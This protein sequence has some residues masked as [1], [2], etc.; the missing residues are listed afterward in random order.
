MASA[1]RMKPQPPR[2]QILNNKDENRIIPAVS[3]QQEGYFNPVDVKKAKGKNMKNSH[4]RNK[5]LGILR[6]AA[7]RR[8]NLFSNI[9][10]QSLYD[11]YKY[12]KQSGRFHL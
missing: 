12:L 1:Q 2:D 5:R 3:R 4:D 9:R 10:S 8:D 11:W 7:A 6:Q